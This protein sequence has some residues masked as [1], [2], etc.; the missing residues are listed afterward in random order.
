[1]RG[2]LRRTELDSLGFKRVMHKRIRWCAHSDRISKGMAAWSARLPRHLG[3]D[4]RDSEVTKLIL[5]AV[6]GDLL[7][8]GSV[9]E[10]YLKLE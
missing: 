4:E 7:L 6:S 3:G 10:V 5:K 2:E 8:S 9:I 1:M